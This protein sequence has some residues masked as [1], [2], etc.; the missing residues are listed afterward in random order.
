MKTEQEL[1]DKL[2]ELLSIDARIQPPNMV[3]GGMAFSKAAACK[4]LLWALGE[5][6][7]DRWY[8]TL[9][10]GRPLLISEKDRN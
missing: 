3:P 5:N 8:I 10:P 6:D 4:A 9:K 1:R 7:D 2:A